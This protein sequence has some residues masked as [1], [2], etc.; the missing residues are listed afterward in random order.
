L[1]FEKNDGVE[2]CLDRLGVTA[3]MFGWA[4]FF[5]QMIIGHSP[6]HA[7]I[8]VGSTNIGFLSF[9]EQNLRK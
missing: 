3:W 4:S 2:A 1:V 8:E 9:H 6:T 7:E 5:L